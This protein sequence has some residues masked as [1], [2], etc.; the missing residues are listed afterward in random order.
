[1]TKTSLNM[2]TLKLF[3]PVLI[4][5]GVLGFLT[6]PRLALMSGA[7]AYNLFHLAFGAL[8]VG[9]FLSRRERL[10]RGFNIGFG[11]L[12]LYQAVASFAGLYPKEL[13]QWKTAD[14]VL[15]VVLGLLLVGVGLFAD[16]GRARP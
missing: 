13:F 4:L 9:L 7:P 5:T 15:H 10:A 8:G 3:A 14:D 12:D 2:L 11:A 6:P 16:R 1:M